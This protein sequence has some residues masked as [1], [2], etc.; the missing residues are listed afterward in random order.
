MVFISNISTVVKAGLGLLKK[1]SQYPL[2]M[3]PVYESEI[4]CPV[5]LLKL[6]IKSAF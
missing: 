6:R 1:Y 5:H 3:T 4:R 2:T